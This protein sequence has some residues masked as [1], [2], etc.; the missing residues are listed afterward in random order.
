M[1]QITIVQNTCL[2]N[3]GD[4]DLQ[5][6]MYT[7]QNTYVDTYSLLTNGSESYLLTD[8]LYVLKSSSY[9]TSKGLLNNTVQT[10]IQVQ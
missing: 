4:A 1:V 7:V 8:S 10:T 3:Y 2:S 9:F 6:P 5:L